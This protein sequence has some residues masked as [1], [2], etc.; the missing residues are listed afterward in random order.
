MATNVI[1]EMCIRDSIIKICFSLDIYYSFYIGH[2][3]SNGELALQQYFGRIRIDDFINI[4]CIINYFN[5]GKSSF[6][7]L[8][9]YALFFI[10]IY[11][12]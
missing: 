1:A 5:Q 10:N 6:K 7:F 9:P 11:A 8:E 12:L 3:I 4:K 2:V